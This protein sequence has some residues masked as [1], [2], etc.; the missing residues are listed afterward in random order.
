ML[1]IEGPDM[2]GK[3]VLAEALATRL[4]E[5]GLPVERDK[6][7]LPE[8]DSML[9]E[10]KRRA[11][12]LRVVDRCWPSEVVYSWAARNQPP[13]VTPRE[14][15]EMMDLFRAAGGLFVVVVA[16]P[17]AYEVLI[18]RHWARGEAFTRDQ[19]RAVNR[20]YDDVF[21]GH[22]R[23]TPYCDFQMPQPRAECHFTVGL[24]GGE[25]FHPSSDRGFVD[26][27]CELYANRQRAIGA[28]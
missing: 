4:R 10:V 25:P 3:T 18:K 11:V 22:T 16:T 15:A 27:V 12:P 9:A 24:K 14:C 2:V 13:A 8:R 23:P 7:G 26:K 28:V 17:Q 5:M 20:A 21:C 1:M 6:F 19:C